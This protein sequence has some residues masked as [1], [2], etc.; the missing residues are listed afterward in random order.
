MFPPNP[1][2]LKRF[3]APRNRTEII[4]DFPQDCAPDHISCISS[5]PHGW[6][7]AARMNNMDDRYEVTVDSYMNKKM[8]F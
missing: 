4:S 3:T 8:F 5:H 2:H 6:A 1:E 7:V